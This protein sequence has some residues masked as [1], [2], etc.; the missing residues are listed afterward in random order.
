MQFES[1]RLLE[2]LVTECPFITYSQKA[3]ALAVLVL[4]IN[5]AKEYPN[6]YRL[7]GDWELPPGSASFISSNYLAPIE[8]S[9]VSSDHTGAS[10][11]TAASSLLSYL[12]GDV[13]K[14][15][16]SSLAL[17]K[18]VLPFRPGSFRVPQLH[19]LRVGPGK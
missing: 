17:R 13:A 1:L 3:E 9:T 5:D 12:Y 11:G 2:N 8:R 15:K 7:D 10:H 4:A 6:S 18:L 16:D 14:Q 19:C